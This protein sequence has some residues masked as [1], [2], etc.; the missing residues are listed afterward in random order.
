MNPGTGTEA[1]PA[2]APTPL[3]GAGLSLVFNGTNPNGTW[4][5]YVVDDQS[6]DSGMITG[7]W[8]L[9]IAT[10]VCPSPTPTPTPIVSVSGTVTY[11][12][13][14]ALN[15]VPGVTMS[16]TGPTPAP[17]STLTNGSGFYTLGGL[18]TGSSYT[19]TP[20][21]TALVPGSAGID[22]VDVIAIQRHFLAIGTPL[23]GCKL[24]A[25]DVN[26]IGGVD[27]V[28]VIA[29]QRFFLSLATG[30]AN[31]GKYSFTPTSRSYSPITTNQTAQ[32]YDALSSLATLLVLCPPSLGW[33]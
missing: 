27:T 23:T 10:S 29:V 13:N 2:P 26:G 15:P 22:T 18:F 1:W 32:N 16:L 14:P 3:Y 9:T 25:A 33:W 6:I 31:T 20:T 11:C 17:T 28:D 5:L 21:K 19:V 4:K 24:T 8:A 30:I 12:T 7:G